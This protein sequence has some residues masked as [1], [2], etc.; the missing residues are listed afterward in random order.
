M[1]Y[2][3]ACVAGFE[4]MR[5]RHTTSE[6]IGFRQRAMD[7]GANLMVLVVE[8]CSFKDGIRQA[9]PMRSRHKIAVRSPV[10]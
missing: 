6:S 2:D 9:I 8:E 4:N 10:R 5:R 3:Q 1:P 7:G